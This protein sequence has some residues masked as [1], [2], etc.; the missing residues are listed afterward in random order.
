MRIL[1]LNTYKDWGGDE[2]WTINIGR[3]LKGKGHH[4]VISSHPGLETEKRAID[5]SHQLVP[6]DRAQKTHQSTNQQAQE[7]YKQ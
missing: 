6:P 3:G 2:K 7:T 4:V 5:I 1:F